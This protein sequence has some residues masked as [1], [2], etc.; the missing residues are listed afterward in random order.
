M[1][2]FH[3]AGQVG[4][5]LNF[6]QRHRH[7]LAGLQ[8]TITQII[9]H[10]IIIIFLE[11]SALVEAFQ[12][13][14]EFVLRLIY[15]TDLLPKSLNLLHGKHALLH[16]ISYNK[17]NPRTIPTPCKTRSTFRSPP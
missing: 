4:D 7:R 15:V 10:Q 13:E 9:Q 5:V 8:T 6:I 2:V 1:Q 14:I 3:H 16:A 12:V 17:V 11:N